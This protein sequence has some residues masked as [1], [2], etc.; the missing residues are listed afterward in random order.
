MGT[1]AARIDFSSHPLC[2]WSCLMGKA[3]RSA[4]YSATCS[5]ARG[6]S[7]KK[8]GASPPRK[9]QPARPKKGLE[10][11]RAQEEFASSQSEAALRITRPEVVTPYA[12]ILFLS[13]NLSVVSHSSWHGRYPQKGD[14]LRL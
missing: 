12:G 10:P 4:G 8:E 5:T 14:G 6:G 2:V 9:R 7:E 1:S 11:I 13:M 3:G